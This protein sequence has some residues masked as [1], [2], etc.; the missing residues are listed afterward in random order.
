MN[1]I[2]SKALFRDDQ[3]IECFEFLQNEFSKFPIYSVILYYYGKFIC[4]SRTESFFGSGIGALQ[5][6]IRV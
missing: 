5:E 1:L 2:Y 3:H 4:L 6:C